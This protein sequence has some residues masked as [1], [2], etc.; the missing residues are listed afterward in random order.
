MLVVQLRSRLANAERLESKAVSEADVTLKVMDDADVFRP[1]GAPLLLLRR[2]AVPEALMD[3]AYEALHSLK[4]HKGYNRG[5]YS[6]GKRFYSNYGDG[7]RSKQSYVL[8]SDGT[9]RNTSS[10][11][12]GYFDRQ[13]GRMPFCRE[14]AFTAQEVARW[15][16]IVPMIQHVGGLFLKN[17]PQRYDRQAT[18]CARCPDYV[19]QGTPFTTLTVNNNGAPAG[20]HKDAGDFKEGLGVMSYVCRGTYDGGWLVFPEYRVGVWPRHGDLVFFNSHE[21]H[22]VTPMTNKSDDA[23]RISI[24]YY[25]RQKM[26]ECLPVAQELQR[27]REHTESMLEQDGDGT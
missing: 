19:I 25:M 7:T 4:S 1:D 22:G 15:K 2:R 8:D 13:G 6:G 17:V 18:E 23:E 11:I 16:T 5:A 14:T 27:A 21:W 3:D 20:V 10:A 26:V 12:I 9:R 24:V